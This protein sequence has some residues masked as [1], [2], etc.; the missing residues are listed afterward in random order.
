MQLLHC[1]LLRLL[2]VLMEMVSIT[3]PKVLELLID[4]HDAF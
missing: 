4:G 3:D 2:K 1:M